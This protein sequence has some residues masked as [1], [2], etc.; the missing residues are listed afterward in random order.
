MIPSLMLEQPYDCANEVTVTNM[1]GCITRIHHELIAKSHQNTAK[2]NRCAHIL[3]KTQWFMFL[4]R[5]DTG[6][7]KIKKIS[8]EK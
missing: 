5:N 1:G 4:H 3:W 8:T 2:Q 7:D 6:E